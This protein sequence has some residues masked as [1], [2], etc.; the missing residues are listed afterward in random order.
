MNQLELQL[1]Q[2]NLVAEPLVPRL[3]APGVDAAS[4]DSKGGVEEEVLR[5][6]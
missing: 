2:H 1:N 5:R 4:V 6:R 3:K